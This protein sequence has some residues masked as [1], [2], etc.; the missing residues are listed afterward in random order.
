VDDPNDPS[1]RAA[2]SR[3]QQ[4]RASTSLL[5]AFHRQ[6][7]QEATALAARHPGRLHCGRGCSTCCLDGLTVLPVEAE[8]IRSAHAGLLA[9]G[10]P[11]AK[12]ACAFLDDEGACRIYP[13]RPY[14]CR[15]QGI[16]MR[17]FQ[18][19]PQGDVHEHRDICP[20]N[21]EGPSLTTLPDDSLWLLGPWEERL[22]R[23]QKRFGGSEARVPL[24]ELFA[25]ANE[26]EEG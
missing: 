21:L 18:E 10:L 12:G 24:R 22:G 23:I 13:D 6:V 17:W 16:P 7:D 1:A 8:R 14:I 4:R 20:E 5:Q 3:A 15:T 19:G 26:E 11:H 25:R 2:A 9:E